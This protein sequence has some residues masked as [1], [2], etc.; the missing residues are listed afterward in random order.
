MTHFFRSTIRGS[1][2][3][4]AARVAG[5]LGNIGSACIPGKKVFRAHEDA[6][7]MGFSIVAASGVVLGGLFFAECFVFWKTFAVFGSALSYFPWSWS[8]NYSA[9]KAADAL[10]YQAISI[11]I[12]TML[13]SAFGLR[14]SLSKLKQKNHRWAS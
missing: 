3:S 8:S 2:R 6:L 9:A 4:F 12:A 13:G 11:S 10:V 1:K 5:S 14:F 7:L